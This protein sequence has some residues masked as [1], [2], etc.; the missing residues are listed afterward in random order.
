M[1]SNRSPAPIIKKTAGIVGLGRLIPG[2]TRGGLS[3]GHLTAST[4]MFCLNGL[5]FR[6]TV[7]PQLFQKL[8]QVRFGHAGNAIGSAVVNEQLAA[9]DSRAA[10]IGERLAN[11]SRR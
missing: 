2:R 7:V 1:K 4:G 9:D 6:L 3:K 10:G 8:L 11:A 5:Q